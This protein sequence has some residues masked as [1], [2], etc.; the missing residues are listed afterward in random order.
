MASFAGML[1]KDWAEAG[2]AN[3]VN[4]SKNRYLHMVKFLYNFR[5]I[6]GLKL[7]STL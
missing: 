4:N 3:P 5:F 2:K 1:S 6:L 7:F